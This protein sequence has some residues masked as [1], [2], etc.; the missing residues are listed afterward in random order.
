MDVGCERLV[1]EEVSMMHRKCQLNTQENRNTT[2][3]HFTKFVV[4]YLQLVQ[5]VYSQTWIG[6]G[7]LLYICV[8]NMMTFDRDSVSQ[9]TNSHFKYLVVDVMYLHLG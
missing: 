2:N 1:P 4:A 9:T 7:P 3:G 6:Q 5:V 8:P